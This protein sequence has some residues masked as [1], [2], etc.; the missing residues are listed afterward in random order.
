[1]GSLFF[2]KEQL[3]HRDGLLP[4]TF[5]FDRSNKQNYCVYSKIG[6]PHSCF[7]IRAFTL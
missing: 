5:A 6:M 1:M 2:Q 3:T 7:P 4:A